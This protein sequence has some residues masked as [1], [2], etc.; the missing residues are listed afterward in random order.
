MVLENIRISHPHKVISGSVQLTGSKSESNRGLIIQS[1]AGG[2][3]HIDNLSAADDTVIL[4]R[5]LNKAKAH[6]LGLKTIDIGP[7][8]T[9]MR[10]LTAY[11]SLLDGE[12]LLT[13]SQRMQQRPIGVL[14]DALTELGATIT[15]ENNSGFPPLRIKGGITKAT[16]RIAIKGN[17]SSQYISALLLI[18]PSLAKGLV[19]DIEGELTSRPYVTMTLEMLKDCGIRSRFEENSIRISPQQFQ[20]STVLI[21]PDWSAASYWYAMVALS[22]KGDMLLPGL[23]PDSLQ[24]DIAIIEIM[25]HFGV[26]SS[27]QKDGLRI[28]KSVVPSEK[29]LFD[30]KSC[31]DLAQTVV[32]V[33]AAQ[34]RDVSFTGL[35]TLKIKETDRIHALQT[36]IAKFGAEL[37]EQQPG[38]Y[39][40]RT[41]NVSDPGNLVFNTYEDHR[42]AMAFAPLALAF[43]TVEIR[44]PSVVEKSYPMFWEHL[45]DQ[46]FAIC[47]S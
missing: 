32:V 29:H 12:F 17:I 44:E 5:A 23:K 11:L 15:Y 18:A 38:I 13:G 2:K 34:G 7:A 30:F 25:K 10:F 33:A 3:V 39:A 28:Y 6:H 19:I 1:L 20:E 43:D 37:N 9:A 16:D 22:E 45:A 8:G 14:V 24:G 27:F 46:G 36:E 41:Q 47:S 42:M 26:A 31:P 40:L 35:E 4:S 21:E